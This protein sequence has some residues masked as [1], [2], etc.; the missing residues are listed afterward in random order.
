MAILQQQLHEFVPCEQT[1][2][3]LPDG[4]KTMPSNNEANLIDSEIIRMSL[5]R[6]LDIFAKLKRQPNETL[7]L[8]FIAIYVGTLFIF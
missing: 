1:G 8:S 3:A 2:P 7:N 4:L 6:R 5:L